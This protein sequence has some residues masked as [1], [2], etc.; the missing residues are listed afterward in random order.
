ME[1]YRQ[2]K[3]SHHID[4][5]LSPT[6]FEK[7][8]IK[9]LLRGAKSPYPSLRREPRP[10]L[11]PI[12]AQLLQQ[13]NLQKDDYNSGAAFTLA[14]AAFLRL[15]EITYRRKKN[16]TSGTLMGITR[17]DICTSAAHDHL[18]HRLKRS[19]TDYKHQG[20]NNMV[21][22][23]GLLTCAVS[24]M[25]ALLGARPAPPTAPLLVLST[26]GSSRQRLVD[27]IK[28][29]LP[30]PARILRNCRALNPTWR[31]TTRC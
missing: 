19:K 6:V 20:V 22:A 15:S 2:A 21:A 28:S 11:P 7:A 31:C 1:S 24:H 30:A 18:I 27:L 3:R 23:S 12:F 8:V 9:R 10:I 14:F 13:G 29:R 4:E 17:A 25:R 5:R 16:L 26:G